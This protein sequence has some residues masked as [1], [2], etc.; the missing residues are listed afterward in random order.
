MVLMIPRRS[1]GVTGKVSGL[2][3][4]VVEGSL[5]VVGFPSLAPYLFKIASSSVPVVGFEGGDEPGVSPRARYSDVTRPPR[6]TDR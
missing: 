4:Q 5:Q 6:L 1:Q 3:R 2:F